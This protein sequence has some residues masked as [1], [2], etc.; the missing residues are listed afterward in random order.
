MLTALTLPAIAVLAAGI[1]YHMPR[2]QVGLSHTPA[3]AP[4]QGTDLAAAALRQL[5]DASTYR[6]SG[7]VHE[8]D[9]G[10]PYQDR[11]TDTRRVLGLSHQ[12]FTHTTQPTPAV[13]VDRAGDGAA[14]TSMWVHDTP[15][16]SWGRD[17]Y[18]WFHDNP[19]Y[20]LDEESFFPVQTTLEAIVNDGTI[21]DQRRAPFRAQLT[22][23][24]GEN[25]TDHAERPAVRLEGSVQSAEGT[26]EFVL[27]T[28]VKGTPLGLSA[29]TTRS[30]ADQQEAEF[31]TYSEYEIHS[32]DEPVD[33]TVPAPDEIGPWEDA[34]G[35]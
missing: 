19:V 11:P 12:W 2:T 13:L 24:M 3:Q 21:A 22:P 20:D 23:A 8:G 17:P 9:G 4:P 26:T 10:G 7:L 25:D 34:G 14:P 5:Q 18:E 33:L 16:I 6:I 31:T 30:G 27:F 28:T 35:P 1:A 32:L 29:E 15:V